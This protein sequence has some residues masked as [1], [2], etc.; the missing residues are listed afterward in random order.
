MSTPT[1]PGPFD[2]RSDQ[3]A[4]PNR[5]GGSHEPV[6]SPGPSRGSSPLDELFSSEPA[7]EPE[8]SY[9]AGPSYPPEQDYQPE[10]PVTDNGGVSGGHDDGHSSHHHDGDGCDH[11]LH[12]NGHFDGGDCEHDRGVWGW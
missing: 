9:D 8:P 12:R 3:P 10:P 2:D 5:A 11:E 7:Y 4:R 6:P 1:E